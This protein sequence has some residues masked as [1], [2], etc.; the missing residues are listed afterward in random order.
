MLVIRGMLTTYCV[1]PLST[2]RPELETL[3]PLHWQ[4]IARDKDDPRFQL[5]PDWDAYHALE[6]AGQFFMNVVRVDGKM[7]G[8]HIAFIRRQLHYADSL[9]LITDIYFVLEEYRKGRIGVEL[10]KESEKAAKARGVDKIYL[11]CKCGS[12]DRSKL[13]EALGYSRIEYVFAKVI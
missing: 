6:A 11:G 2:A 12:L 5:K 13:F 8:Y 9:A 4:E 10:F 1:E 7:V 3:L